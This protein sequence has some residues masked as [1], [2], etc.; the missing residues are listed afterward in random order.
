MILTYVEVHN[1]LFEDM[2]NFLTQKYQIVD[3]KIER[4]LRQNDSLKI[5]RVNDN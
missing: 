3:V 4:R 1:I 5:V 2:K